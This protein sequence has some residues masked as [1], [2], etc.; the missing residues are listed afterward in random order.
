LPTLLSLASDRGNGMSERGQIINGKI[1][2]SDPPYQANPLIP[3]SDVD[4]QPAS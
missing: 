2:L 3:H 4:Y 1:I